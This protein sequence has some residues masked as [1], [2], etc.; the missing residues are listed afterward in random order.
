MS[1]QKKQI[2]PMNKT[3]NNKFHG[4]PAMMN[5][6]R[7]FT[8]YRQ[9]TYVNDM[10]RFSN[11][12]PDSYQYRQFLIHN[13]NNIM[14]V[15]QKYTKDKVHCNGV[16]G[17]L[18]PDQ[19]VCSFN[20]NNSH[21]QMIHPRGQGVYNTVP[22]GTAPQLGMEGKIHGYTDPSVLNKSAFAFTPQFDHQR[23]SHF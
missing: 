9:S 18:I 22:P 6:G 20:T 13:G 1:S 17:V 11:H 15:N 14:S 12:I 2:Q 23:F 8:D 19:S 5:D 7:I 4:C 21:C 10:I 3:C 16:N